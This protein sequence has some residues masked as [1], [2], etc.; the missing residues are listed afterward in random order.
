MLLN[1]AVLVFNVGPEL[2][3]IYRLVCAHDVH[4]MH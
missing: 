4:K 3:I 2:A 1:L